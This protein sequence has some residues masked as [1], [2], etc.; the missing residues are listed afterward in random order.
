M[1]VQFVFCTSSHSNHLK[2]ERIRLR[3]WSK[4]TVVLSE[5]WWRTPFCWR[6]YFVNDRQWHAQ[7]YYSVQGNPEWLGGHIMCPA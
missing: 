4:L 1:M 5:L 2:S 7:D 3:R 6:Y